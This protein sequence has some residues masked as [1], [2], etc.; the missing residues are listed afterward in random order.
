MK[1]KFT[2]H[3]PAEKAKKFSFFEK[4]PSLFKNLSGLNS[5]T[6]SQ[7]DLLLLMAQKWSRTH[8]PFGIS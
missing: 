1:N 4:V 5:R 7:S 8:V 2:R 6:S 3:A